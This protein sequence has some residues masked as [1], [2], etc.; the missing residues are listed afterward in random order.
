MHYQNKADRH[1]EERDS[2]QQLSLG[3]LA[4]RMNAD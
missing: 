2:L 4:G 3:R 1:A